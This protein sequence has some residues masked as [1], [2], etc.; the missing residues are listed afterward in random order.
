MTEEQKKEFGTT[1]K[2]RDEEQRKAFNVALIEAGV[3]LK[4]ALQAMVDEFTENKS[5]RKA[6]VARAKK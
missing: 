2:Y 6:V 4:D 1:L 5:H 3:S